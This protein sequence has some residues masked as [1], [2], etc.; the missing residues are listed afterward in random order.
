MGDLVGE[1]VSGV[2]MVAVVGME[3]VGMGQGWWREE[4]HEYRVERELREKSVNEE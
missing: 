3:E 1:E 4:S 2:D